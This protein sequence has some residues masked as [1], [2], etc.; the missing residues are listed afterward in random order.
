MMDEQYMETTGEHFI[1]IVAR[2]RT[3][4]REMCYRHCGGDMQKCRDLEQDVAIV[5][6]GRYRNLPTHPKAETRW[7]KDVVRQTLSNIRRGER[8][9]GRLVHGNPD[10]SEVQDENIEMM[11]LLDELRNAS[12]AVDYYMFLLTL[13]G[14][15][16]KGIANRL[17]VSEQSVYR[18]LRR[19]RDNLIM[20]KNKKTH[21]HGTKVF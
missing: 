13:K 4:I 21:S 15:D 14:Y 3:L 10:G 18:R 12:E 20:I 1:A 19:I 9:L 6:W 16:V 11:E 7:V 5:L 8:T 2:H 17:G